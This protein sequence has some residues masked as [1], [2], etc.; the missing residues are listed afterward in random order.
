MTTTTPAGWYPDP[1]GGTALRW[2]DGTSW[3][4]HTQAAAVTPPAGQSVFHAAPVPSE[5][6][7]PD[8][9]ASGRPRRRRG[10][11]VLAVG[12]ATA[13]VLVGGGAAFAYQTLAAKGASPE[14]VIPAS[15]LGY[16]KVDLDPPA[17][18]KVNALQT[19]RKLNLPAN[20]G[21]DLSTTVADALAEQ[22]NG[23]VDAAQVKSWLGKRFAVA[24]MSDSDTGAY[25][26][27]LVAS[28]NDEAA[29]ATLAAASD[30]NGKAVHAFRD[31]YLI[32]TD[33]QAHLDAYTA[34]LTTGALT[35]NASWQQDIDSVGGDQIAVVWADLHRVAT[36]AGTASKGL[37]ALVSPLAPGILPG[38]S[39]AGGDQ[40]KEALAKV[41]GRVIIGAHFTNNGA[42]I[43]GRTNGV[44][45]DAEAIGLARSH[46]ATRK[47]P[48]D[49]AVAVAVNG[50]GRAVA[51]A[52]TQQDQTV[53]DQV[54]QALSAVGMTLDDVVSLTAGDVA[55]AFLPESGGTGLVALVTEVT[56]PARAE[57]LVSPLL[58][59]APGGAFTATDDA[60]LYLAT[61][62]A[63]LDK[64]KAGGA[65]GEQPGFLA[66]VADPDAAVVLYADLTKFPAAADVPVAAV[67]YSQ[68]VTG[69]DSSFTL[70]VI[71][72]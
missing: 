11:G 17:G 27:L 12:L 52:I 41:S 36:A 5:P 38:G 66:A 53:K 47:L 61:N 63:W 1:Y 69:S 56:D 72:K 30:G 23:K 71:L 65:L 18:Q 25:A 68:D 42:E 46:G 6:A 20:D 7:T 64:V 26:V 22:S 33:T 16:L 59:A 29:A 43:I 50:L 31:G 9:L 45:T 51:T 4:E 15:A 37:G 67:G 60:H 54:N 3:T 39:P 2:F 13:L 35:D 55:G 8:V 44:A 24:A 34:A 58:A 32:A 62:R 70:R 28:M 10:K 57:S 49:A 40:L 19:L 48:S 14:Q 21:G